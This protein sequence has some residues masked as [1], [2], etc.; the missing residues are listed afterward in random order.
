MIPAVPLNKTGHD[1]VISGKTHNNG[2]DIMSI[3]RDIEYAIHIHG[4]WKTR[5]RDFLSGRAPMD[6]SV[7]GQPDA[8]KLGHWL[9]DEARRMLSPEDHAE[10]CRLHEHFH[11]VAGAIVDSIKQ[12]DYGAARQALGPSGTFDQASHGLAAFLRK[13][14]LRDKPRGEASAV[15][16][17]RTSEA[18]A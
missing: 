14:P 1:A 16:E 4:V 17:A 9:N 6:M 11:Q 5:F 8:C 10:A 13:M 3:K 7:V 12:K 15:P 18:A 2:G